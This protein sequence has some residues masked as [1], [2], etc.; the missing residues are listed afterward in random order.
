MQMGTSL[1]FEETQI[2]GFL[3]LKSYFEA[4]KDGK[5]ALEKCPAEMES[6]VRDLI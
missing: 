2:L 3:P 5:S 4:K 6:A 1:I